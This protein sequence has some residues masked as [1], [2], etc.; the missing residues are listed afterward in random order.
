MDTK[1]IVAADDARLA[2]GARAGARADSAAHGSGAV[3][4]EA[5]TEQLGPF[6]AVETTDPVDR[7]V[8]LKAF[9]ERLFEML[10][11]HHGRACA[12]RQSQA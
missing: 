8:T 6:A 2:R 10:D 4:R 3:V 1:T 12:V 11:E 5:L 9:V 7:R